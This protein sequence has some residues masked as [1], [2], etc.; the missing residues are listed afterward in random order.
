MAKVGGG[1]WQPHPPW[2]GRVREPHSQNPRGVRTRPPTVQPGGQSCQQAGHLGGSPGGR[3]F[4]SVGFLWETGSPLPSVLWVWGPGEGPLL[5]VSSG[6]RAGGPSLTGR[7]GRTSQL[8]PNHGGGGGRGEG[9]NSGL[10]RLT[11]DP[12]L[13][14]PTSCRGWEGAHAP[15]SPQLHFPPLSR[16]PRRRRSLRGTADLLLSTCLR[17]P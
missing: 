14:W 3:A 11:S 4:P 9:G 10:S 8:A 1:V 6:G 5:F 15:S 2:T 17:G 7:R 12:P 16:P 13:D